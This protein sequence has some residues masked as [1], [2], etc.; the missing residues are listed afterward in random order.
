VEENL[1]FFASLFNTT[2]EENYALVADIYR[3]LEPFSKRRAGK[4]SGGMKQKLAL[5]CALIHKPEVLF[6]DEPTTGVD[7]VSRVEFWNML[8]KLQADGI[9][10]MVS[11]AYMDEASICDRIALMQRGEIMQLDTPARIAA[12]FPHK[13]YAVDSIGTFSQLE[14]LRSNG[15]VRSAFSFGDKIHITFNGN[16]D[17]SIAGLYEI[18]PSVEDCFIELGRG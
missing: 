13:L 11:T 18:E 3:Q 16:A 15:S 8:K 7:P 6:L 9:T 10:I 14:A 17:T 4:L 1:T 12:S 2:I 5:C